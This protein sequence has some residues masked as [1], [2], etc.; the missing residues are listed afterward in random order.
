MFFSCIYLHNLAFKAVRGNFGPALL[1]ASRSAINIPFGFCMVMFVEWMNCGS[2]DTSRGFKS[3]IW[4]S[5][6]DC[7][8]GGR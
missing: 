7:D 2:S 3:G 6:Y 1:A 5:L 8:Q 4:Y